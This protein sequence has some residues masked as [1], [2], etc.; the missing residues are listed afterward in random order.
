VHALSAQDGFTFKHVVLVEFPR[1]GVYSLGF[2]MSKFPD[3]LSPQSTIP[4]YSI[5]IPTTPNPTTGFFI[6]SPQHEFTIVD[7]T[8][9]EAMTLIVS[10]GI[11]QPERF[12]TKE[13]GSSTNS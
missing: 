9:Q 11:L 5:Y 3:H 1:K 4:L 12:A 6:L 2:V 7:L 10:G 8:R 13:M